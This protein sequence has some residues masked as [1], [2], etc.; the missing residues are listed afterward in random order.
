MQQFAQERTEAATPRRIQKA[1]ERGQVFKSAELVSAITLL[2]AYVSLAVAGPAVWHVLTQFSTDTWGRLAAATLTPD[3]VHRL[4]LTVLMAVGL[5][6]GPVLLGSLVAG[7]A[8]NYA[9]VGFLFSLQPLVPDMGRLNPLSGLQRIFSRRSAVE[10]LKAAVKTAIISLVA[11]SAVRGQLDRFPLMLDQPIEALL[12]SVGA[13]VA[14]VMLRV[15][16]AML[17]VAGADYAYQRYEF[18]VQMR[19][20]KQEIKEEYRETEGSPEVKSRIRRKQRELARR[21]MMQE[22]PRAD[23]VVTNPT[24]F[25]V[26]LRYDSAEMDAPQV[27][28]KGQGYVAQRIREVAAEHDVP[29]VENPPLART[30]YAAV[31]IGAG[32]PEDLYQAVAEI[33]AYVYRLRAKTL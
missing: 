22:V 24:H 6:A 4:S 20:T 19:M 28:A 12:G 18:H 5:A 30:L 23:V 26:A 33:L 2:A 8:A 14:A 7:M 1:R 17:L 3:D 15:G 27:V 32:V 29:V 9:Q 31:E 25:A 13:M 10:L 11:Y 16:L 21:R